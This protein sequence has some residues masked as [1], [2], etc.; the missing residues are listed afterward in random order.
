MPDD[1]P[2]PEQPAFEPEKLDEDAPVESNPGMTPG[3]PVEAATP[4]E[5]PVIPPISEQPPLFVEDERGRLKIDW[6][7][8][9]PGVVKITPEALQML[10]NRAN[11]PR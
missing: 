8:Q 11:N 3:E 4:G 10:V 6:Q 9:S 5:Q 1:Q 7:G 2:E